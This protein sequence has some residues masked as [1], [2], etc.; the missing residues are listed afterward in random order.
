[1]RNG[2][3]WVVINVH[4]DGSVEVR[5][6]GRQWGEYRAASAAHVRDHVELGNA[7]ISQRAQGITT[8]T[9]HVVVAP[10]VPRENLYVAMTR[11]REASSPY[12]AVDRPDVAHVGPRPGDDGDVTARSILFAF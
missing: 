6:H 12:V 10:C 5:R 1:M 4:R 9:A 8:D 7:V 11:G 3:R 2:D